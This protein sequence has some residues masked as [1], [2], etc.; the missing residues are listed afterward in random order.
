MGG[1]F[2]KEM[3]DYFYYA[4][5]RAQGE[6]TIEPRRITGRVPFAEL[7][8]LMRAIGYYPS[9][10]EIDEIV[11]E[12]ALA[13]TGSD[14]EADTG[15]F[16]DFLRLYVNHRPVL[17]TSKEALAGAFKAIGGLDQSGSISRDE[18]LRALQAHGE[19]LSMN[20]LAQCLRALVGTTDIEGVLGNQVGA[21]NFAEAVLGFED[22][23]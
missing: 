6:D 2:Y 21:P 17:G 13:Q 1:E 15:G 23:Q 9:E 11:Q 8:N 10:R 19:S 22:Y 4:Q 12:A 7:G 16:G 18:L 3:V 20:D 14:E 5:L